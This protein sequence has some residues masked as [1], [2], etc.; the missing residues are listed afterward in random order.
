MTATWDGVQKRSRRCGSCRFFEGRI[1]IGSLV[2]FTGFRVL[3][4]KRGYFRPGCNLFVKPLLE[5]QF[6]S[7]FSSTTSH[8]GTCAT[9]SSSASN[10]A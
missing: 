1:Q 2:G 9:P 5:Y 3:L 10:A 4:V 7:I 6:R 8:V